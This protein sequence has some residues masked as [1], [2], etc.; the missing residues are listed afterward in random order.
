MYKFVFDILAAAD[1]I[2]IHTDNKLEAAVDLFHI[3]QF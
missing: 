2:P 3:L 1:H